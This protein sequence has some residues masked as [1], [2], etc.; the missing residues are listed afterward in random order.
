M[1]NDI[2]FDNIYIGHSIA[3]AE[4]LQKQ[5]FDVKVA[6]EKQEEEQTKPKKDETKAPS[7]PMDLKF[8]DDPV[9]YV[10]EKFSLFM[11][12]AKRDPVEAVR[13]VP[14]IAGGLAVGV[15]TLLIILSGL[16]AGGSKAAPSKEQINAKAQQAKDAAL[17]TK[18]QVAEAVATGTQ[19]AKDEVNKRSKRNSTV[20]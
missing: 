4:A 18:D 16:L 2:L 15:I 8:L 3:D 20:Q 9:L 11:E 10:T 7:S 12:I 17:K 1:Q 19:Q 5:T 13:F 14:E 6:V